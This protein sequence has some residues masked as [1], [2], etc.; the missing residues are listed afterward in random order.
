[1]ALYVQHGYGKSDKIETA[2]QADLISGVIISPRDETPDNAASFIENLRTINPNIEV[3]FDPQFFVSTITPLNCGKLGN[4]PYFRNNLSRRD[5]ITPTDLS[6]YVRESL[7][8]QNNNLN[9]TRL[10]SPNIMFDDFNDTWSQIS[11]SLSYESLTYYRTLGTPVPLLIC[12]VFNE[13]AF[14]N[15][16]AM[17]DFLNVISMLDVHGFYLMVR[18]EN[19][20]DPFID[21]NILES[22]M[23]FAYTLATINEYEV[24]LG[25]TNF[26]GIPLHA[27]GITASACGWFNG[28][29]QFTLSRFQPSSGGRRPRPAYSS[30]NLLNSI[31]VS[32]EL[33]TISNLGQI[34]LVTSNNVYDREL[35]QNPANAPWTAASSCLHH[36]A[37]LSSIINQIEAYSSITSRLDLIERLIAKAG[38]I[39]TSLEKSLVFE[40]NSGRHH[41][42][43][44]KQ[45]IR[46]FRDA[47]GE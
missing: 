25:Y 37:V 17:N 41:I 7:D 29:K 44:W 5:F 3:L 47:V 38:R 35:I 18:R 24:V 8:Y 2:L 36:W 1:M 9:I 27:V 20:I 30:A 10:I 39:Y 22:L 26:I 11:L 12:L 40:Y 45:G 28:L 43:Q 32:P 16:T 42:P 31:L 23:Y 19:P 15:R 6:T 14:R 4:Y 33:T 46:Q 21:P 34:D 13:S